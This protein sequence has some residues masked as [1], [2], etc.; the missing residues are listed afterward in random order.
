MVDLYKRLF[1]KGERTL[2]SISP[3]W[4]DA[5]KEAVGYPGSDNTKAEIQAWAA[6]YGIALSDGLTKAEML[7][8]LEAEA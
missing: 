1:E 2:H 8:K 5:V 4:R 6:N 3:K 7:A